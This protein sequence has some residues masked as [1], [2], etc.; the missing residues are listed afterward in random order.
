[1]RMHYLNS[2]FVLAASLCC[3]YA[4]QS[5]FDENTYI[6]NGQ[7]VFEFHATYNEENNGGWIS[8]NDRNYLKNS[9][10]QTFTG[11][12]GNAESWFDEST[13]KFPNSTATVSICNFT[14]PQR[15]S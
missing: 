5:S 13:R 8:H 11:V 14:Q 2:L 10:H 12:G 9:F 1:M 4:A 3:C 7:Y 15:V 6:P